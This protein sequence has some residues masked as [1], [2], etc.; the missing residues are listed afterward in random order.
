MKTTRLAWGV[1]AL[2]LVG[3]ADEVTG[4]GPDEGSSS[5]GTT[6]DPDPTR[7]GST[8]SGTRGED[9]TTTGGDETDASSSS[10][11]T[12]APQTDTGA[13]STGVTAGTE[14]DGETDTETDGA[15]CGDGA[16]DGGEACDDGG[17]SEACNVDCTV[18][19]CGDGVLNATAGEVCDDAGES[20]TC[21]DDCT[22]ASCGDM[23]VNAAAGEVCDDGAETAAC[24]VDCTAVACGDGVANETAGEACDDGA[25]SEDCDADC[26]AVECGDGSINAAAGEEC[27]GGPGCGDECAYTCAPFSAGSIAPDVDFAASSIIGVTAGLAWDG[28]E[29][30]SVSGG[31]ADGLRLAQHASDG[32]VLMTYAPDFDFRSV[33][34]QGDGGETIFA[35]EFAQSTLSTM[36]SPGAF[37]TDVTL[38]P[39]EPALGSQAA[40]VWNDDAD[41][42]VALSQAVVL[43]WSAD[44][45]FIGITELEGL[46]DA[47][48]AE[49]EYPSNR[50][51]AW[52]QGCYL[53]YAD[54][55]VS[56]WDVQGQRVDTATL[57]DEPATLDSEFSLSY[58]NGRIFVG[59][60]TTFR[61]YPAW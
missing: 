41:E 18:A 15:T 5:T 50:S 20:E 46:G 42:F 19:A 44:G 7:P 1:A 3:C 53:T 58:A 52:G 48:P 33:F 37:A 28:T 16:V 40:V 60:G 24:D 56:S 55:I 29:L 2:A 17:E 39:A 34:T 14:T 61:G 21:N 43:R 59:D 11:T 13:T 54:G 32:A 57:E 4:A 8:S 36:T 47:V 25:D 23:V 31:E 27:E 9:D 6:S 22:A 12:G 10:S 45:T 38:A 35:R 26:T 51:L 30:W 49:L